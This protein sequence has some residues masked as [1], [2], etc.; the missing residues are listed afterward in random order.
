[1]TIARYTISCIKYIHN[2]QS[3]TLFP[4]IF[5][6]VNMQSFFKKMTNDSYRA[7][8]KFEY[9]HAAYMYALRVSVFLD[10]ISLEYTH[11][12]I[13]KAYKAMMLW[14]NAYSNQNTICTHGWEIRLGKNI[15]RRKFNP[16]FMT[17][18]SQLIMP[19]STKEGLHFNEGWKLLLSHQNKQM[20]TTE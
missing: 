3:S 11:Y 9:P 5:L 10:F 4:E 7:R 2:L 19:V 8:G 6:F 18:P 1:M 12:L 16:E 14:R 20:K 13:L 17:H 15:R